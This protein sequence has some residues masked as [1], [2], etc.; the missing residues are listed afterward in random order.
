MRKPSRI[1]RILINEYRGPCVKTSKYLCR[2][3]LSA[4]ANQRLKFCARLPDLLAH[5]PAGRGELARFRAIHIARLGGIAMAARILFAGLSMV[6]LT[7]AQ[8]QDSSTPT[9]NMTPAPT[10]LAPTPAAKSTTASPTAATASPTAA[11][12]SSPAQGMPPLAREGES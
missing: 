9:A 12:I 7:V 1:T 10:S 6:V 5:S 3:A 2:C 11:D 4:S 8:Q